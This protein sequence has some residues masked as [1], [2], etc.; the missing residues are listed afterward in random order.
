MPSSEPRLTRDEVRKQLAARTKSIAD[1]F[2]ALE[3][4]LPVKPRTVR[5]LLD[6][7]KQIKRFAALGAGVIAVA[8]MYRKRKETSLT[9]QDGLDKISEAIAFE[10]RN[11]L[12]TGMN[13]DDAVYSALRKRPPV[14]KVGETKQGSELSGTFSSVM[15]QLVVSLGPSLIELLSE[16]AR[17]GISDDSRK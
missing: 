12:K 4:E 14:V 1:R 2:S 6:N 9:Y 8:V 13:A 7:K 3:T 15:K 5:K 10:V 16:L 17:G 11:N